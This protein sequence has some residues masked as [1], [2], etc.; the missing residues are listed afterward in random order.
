MKKILLLTLLLVSS[1][2]F[3]GINVSA[4]TYEDLPGG[5][6]GLKEMVNKY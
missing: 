6:Q 2:A 5:V 3:T 4:A 1:L